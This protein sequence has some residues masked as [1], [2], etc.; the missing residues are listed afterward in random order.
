MR[1]ISADSVWPSAT[2]ATLT[3]SPL[4]VWSSVTPHHPADLVV[5]HELD[6]DEPR[7]VRGGLL[8][9]VVG[10]GLDVALQL[11]R[12]GVLR[13]GEHQ[14][15]A[16]SGLRTDRIERLGAT[17]ISLQRHWSYSL[18]ANTSASSG[19]EAPTVP[20]CCSGSSALRRANTW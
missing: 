15:A 11:Q 12:L 20:M 19:S 17:N 13:A 4:G 2:I 6:L 5:G 9:R 7:V 10:I 16:H 14:V 18:K 8:R 1:L 3:A